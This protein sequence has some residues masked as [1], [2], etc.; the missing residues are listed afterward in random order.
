MR[1][2]AWLM[3]LVGCLDNPTFEVDTQSLEMP[4][5]TSRD[6]AVSL[7]GVPLDDLFSVVWQVEDP[8]IVTVTPAWD[9]RRLRVGGALPGETIVRVNS[10]GQTFE[11]PTRVGAPAIV[12]VWIEP[13]TVS[14]SLGKQVHVKATGLD[15]MYQLQDVTRDSWWTVRD[16]HIA[17]LDMAG[18]MLEAMAPGHTTL[19]A[20]FGELT[21]MTDSNIAK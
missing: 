2:F 3:F 13:S 11:I 21:S 5:G 14:T 20:T 6:I 4:Q 1:G 15:T 9:G 16:E 10:H 17:R 18:M 8:S 7:D 19:H 12:Y